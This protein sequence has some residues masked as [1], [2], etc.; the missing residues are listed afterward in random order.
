MQHYEQFNKNKVVDRSL[1]CQVKYSTTVFSADSM[2]CKQGNRKRK[3]KNWIIHKL[4]NHLI[5]NWEVVIA[6]RPGEVRERVEVGE[7]WFPPESWEKLEGD[8]LEC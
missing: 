5:N 6:E 1:N 7:G 4:D 8:R 2:V 3:E